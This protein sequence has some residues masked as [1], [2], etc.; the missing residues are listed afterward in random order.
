MVLCCR[1]CNKVCSV[2]ECL[3]CVFFS[4]KQF[5]YYYSF[6]STHLLVEDFLYITFCFMVI[7][8]LVTYNFNT[9]SPC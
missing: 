3:Y 9:F 6:K 5:L 1:H 8:Q 7:C 4:Y 2:N